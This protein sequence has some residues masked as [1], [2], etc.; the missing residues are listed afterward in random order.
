MATLKKIGS[1]YSARFTK[2]VNNKRQEKQIALGTRSKENAKKLKR[3]L[4]VA[5]ELG[6]VNIFGHFDFN[7]WKD[8]DL[9]TSESNS[10]HLLSDVIDEFLRVRVD[11]NEETHSNYEW[12][13]KKFNLETGITMPFQLVKQS[14]II[15]FAFEE[16]LAVPSQNNYLRHLKSFFNWAEENGYKNNVCKKLK[17]KTVVDSLHEQIISEAQLEKII[18]S[19]SE[20]IKEQERKRCI[21]RDSQ[22][23]LWFAP[24]ITFTYYT[25]LRI[26]EVLNLKW[27]VIDFSEPDFTFV[28]KNGKIRTM[29]LMDIPRKALKKW[30]A[31]VNSDPNRYIFESPKSMQNNSIKM[32]NHVSKVFK[33]HVRRSKMDENIHFHS[34]RHS[35]ATN[36]IKLGF[37][38]YS[39]KKMM[40]HESISVTEVYLHIVSAD[41]TEKGRKLGVLS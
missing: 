40:G 13:L 20:Y 28:G 21:T 12:L 26:S 19:H 31:S 24:L 29:I 17:K 22:R 3:R 33:K 11:L 1:K 41:I 10:N 35:C 5:Y 4:E 14:D 25:G 34:L 7:S 27:K 37:D 9:N 16:H 30:K 39:V 23:Q 38:I 32:T 36:L 18:T 15:N 6:E 8:G 2:T